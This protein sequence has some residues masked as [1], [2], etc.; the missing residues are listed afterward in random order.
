ML[1]LNPMTPI[2]DAYR[3]VILFGRLPPMPEMAAVFG[4][5]VIM[6]GIA[7]VMFHRAEHQLGFPQR[8]PCPDAEWC[9]TAGK[10]QPKVDRGAA[11][12]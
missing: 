10:T 7:W 3:D 8:D 11:R 1:S 4:A 6:L 2:L 5:S 12:R 9:G